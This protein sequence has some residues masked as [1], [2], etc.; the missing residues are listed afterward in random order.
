M[1]KYAFVINVFR[2]DGFHSGGERV[3][4]ELVNRA[5]NN[6][7]SVDLYCASYLGQNNILKPKINKITIIGHP[8]DFKYPHKIENFYNS[9]KNYIQNENYDRVISENISP[10]IDIGILQ[11]H[12]LA[13]YKKFSGNF[14][15]KIV[16]CLQ[17]YKY[18][19]AQKNW[20]KTKYNKIIVP[21]IVLKEELKANFGI[22]ENNFAVIYPGVDK[23]EIINNEIL[24]NNVFTIGLSAPSFSKKGGYLFL[25]A[26][27]IMKKQGYKFKAKIIYPKAEKNIKLKLMIIKYGLKNYI[28]FLPYQNDMQHFYSSIDTLVV[29]SYLETF[30]LVALEAMINKKP[31]IIS[32]LCGASEILKD[33]FNGYIFNMN[34]NISETIAEKLIN[35]IKDDELRSSIANNAYETALKYNWKAFCDNFFEESNRNN[36][37]LNKP[38]KGI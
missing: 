14:I 31:V 1:K 3:F 20:L 22:D 21:S 29:P 24:K 17:K 36:F 19:N 16:Y 26:L 6:G 5:V 18:I 4:Y 34:K 9:V 38:E 27:Y 13:H 33:G 10:P 11:G 30:G 15:S 23:P 35:I 7:H 28:E 25:K 32:S 8:K 37:V 2:E 12:S